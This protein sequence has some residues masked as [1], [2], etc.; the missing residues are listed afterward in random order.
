MNKDMF[1]SI[2]DTN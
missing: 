1:V 2:I